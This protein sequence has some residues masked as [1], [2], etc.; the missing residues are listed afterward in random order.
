MV[1]CSRRSRSRAVGLDAPMASARNTRWWLENKSN[2]Q[3]RASPMMAV[4]AIP[5]GPQN[6]GA[7]SLDN[8]YESIF[9]AVWK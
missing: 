8:F 1:D 5:Q 2:A 6:G 4:Q 7:V 3:R 9:L